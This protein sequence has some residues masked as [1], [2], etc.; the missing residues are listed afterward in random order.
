MRPAR[1]YDRAEGTGD[2]ALAPD[3]LA[4]VGLGHPKLE[5][6]RAV[7]LRARD[8]HLVGIVDEALGQVGDELLQARKFLAPSSAA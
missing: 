2:A 4:D 3:H 1:A 6:R 8:R 7:S 5:H